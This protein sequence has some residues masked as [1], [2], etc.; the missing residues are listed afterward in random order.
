MLIDHHAACVNEISDSLFLNITDPFL[1]V[2]LIV[3]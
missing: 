3:F 1:R 2:E